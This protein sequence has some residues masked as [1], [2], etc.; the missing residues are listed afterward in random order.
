MTLLPKKMG[1]STIYTGRA[2]T[3]SFRPNTIKFCMDHH[4]GMHYQHRKFEGCIL[5]RKKVIYIYR[6]VRTFRGYCIVY[7]DIY[8]YIYIYIYMDTVYIDIYVY[9]NIY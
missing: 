4:P 5:N 2:Q 7:I 6:P 8:K 9:I 3:K 1:G